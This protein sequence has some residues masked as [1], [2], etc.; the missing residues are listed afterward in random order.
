LSSRAAIDCYV[1]SPPQSKTRCPRT[2]P[3]PPFPPLAAVEF[4]PEFVTDELP[5]AS[6]CMPSCS[7]EHAAPNPPI[8]GSPRALRRRSAM[9]VAPAAEASLRQIR[10]HHSSFDSDAY[11]NTLRVSSRAFW[12]YPCLVPHLVADFSSEPELSRRGSSTPPWPPAPSGPR[13][14]SPGCARARGTLWCPCRGLPCPETP[15]AESAAAL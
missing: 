11:T 6:P 3:T 13:D 1:D 4:D 10:P 8:R 15:T 9:A 2:T 14:D 7:G 5:Q 12:F